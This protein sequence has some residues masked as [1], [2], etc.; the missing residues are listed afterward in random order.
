M[1]SGTGKERGIMTLQQQALRAVQLLP[2]EKLPALI[3]FA[4][5]L[6]QAGRMA[7]TVPAQPSALSEQRRS[8]SG[9]LKGQ[10][11]IAEDFNETPD[12]FKEYL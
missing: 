3:E 2:E 5:F 12:V 8:L 10:V 9:I 6:N 11:R 7:Q 1:E 4:Q